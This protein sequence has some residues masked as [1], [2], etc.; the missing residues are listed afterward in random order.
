M[1]NREPTSKVNYE[2]TTPNPY[3]PESSSIPPPPPPEWYMHQRT[4]KA[5]KIFIPFVLLLFGLT[6]GILFYPTVSALY[7]HSISASPTPFVPFANPA[8]QKQTPI[9][10]LTPQSQITPTATANTHDANAIMQDLLQAGLQATNIQYG[11]PACSN[12]IA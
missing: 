3:L 8:S 10:T 7:N 9:P 5:W 2:H 6:L 1:N 4:G 12:K 11:V